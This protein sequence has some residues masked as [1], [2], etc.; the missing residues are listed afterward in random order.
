MELPGGADAGGCSK[1]GS[2]HPP[3]MGK[4]SIY[5]PFGANNMAAYCQQGTQHCCEPS[6]TGS[7]STCQPMATPCAA[8]ETDWQC[9]DP[10][11]CGMGAQCCS[12]AGAQW[13]MG[14]PG[15]ANFGSHFN[16]SHCAAH[17]L[18]GQADPALDELTLCTST[19]QCAN[20]TTCTTMSTKG[21]QI[22]VCH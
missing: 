8:K 16:G 19:S 12:N 9:Q 4:P 15:C 22:G 3:K 6:G 2:L 20:G 21:V 14:A 13:V 7:V 5:C 17:C 11:D 1:P 10:S 18:T